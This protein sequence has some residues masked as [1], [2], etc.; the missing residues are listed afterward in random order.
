MHDPP[1]GFSLT[2]ESF[3]S[4]DAHGNLQV[5]FLSHEVTGDL[6]ADIDIDKAGGIEHGFEVI[7]NAVLHNR[8]NPFAIREILLASD[9]I[10]RS[11]DPGYQLL[12]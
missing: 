5:T 7:G 8:T 3:K 6:A 12:C 11:L 9:P 2:G 1:P 10:N 4:R